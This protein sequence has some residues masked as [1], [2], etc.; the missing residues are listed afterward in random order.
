M[1]QFPKRRRIV[2]MRHGEVSYFVDGRPVPPPEAQLNNEGRIQAATAAQLLADIPFDRAVA[3]G[4]SRTM[5]TARIVLATRNLEIE[6]VPELQEIRGGRMA[7]LPRDEL[8]RVFLNS[9]THHLAEDSQ[10]LMGDRFGDFRDRVVP[11]FHRLL[12]NE[13]W[14]NLLIVAHGAV[15]RAILA[16]VLHAPI[17]AMGHIEQDAGCV[18]MIDVDERGYGIIRLLNYTPYNPSKRGMDLTTMERYFL[19][20]PESE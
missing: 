18:N 2:L 11:A 5:E 13:H 6:V 3:T 16:D 10:F 7:D 1:E 19:E 12:E 9:M 17:E 8:R 15:N 4:L 20:F 14:Q